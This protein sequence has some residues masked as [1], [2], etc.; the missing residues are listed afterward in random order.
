MDN[1]NIIKYYQICKILLNNKYIII[2]KVIKSIGKECP[3]TSCQTEFKGISSIH[4]DAELKEMSGVTF[5][6]FNRLLKGLPDNPAPPIDSPNKLLLF[7]MKLKQG[8]SF[9]VLALLFKVKRHVIARAFYETLTNLV[10]LLK[11]SEYRLS[12]DALNGLPLALKDTYPNCCALVSSVE[13]RVEIPDSA[14]ERKNFYGMDTSHGY[15][16]LFG[17]APNGYI[18]YKS[19]CHK[20]PRS[21]EFIVRDSL[22]YLDN[23]EAG[24][25]ILA[26]REIPYLRVLICDKGAEYVAPP[27]K[28]YLRAPSV[29]WY[30]KECLHRLRLFKGLMSVSIEVLPQIDEVVSVCCSLIN[31]QFTMFQ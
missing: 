28:E 5:S 19:K 29:D 24:Y 23:I 10:A 15:K 13:M 1:V 22:K 12:G 8:M 11:T 9:Q 25:V 27:F 2:I 18:T 14:E 7:L 16:F 26:D 31:L 3:N 30:V 21:N 20:G 17:C 6:V 4:T